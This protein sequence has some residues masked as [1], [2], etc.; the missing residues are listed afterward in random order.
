MGWSAF[1]PVGLTHHNPTSS[2]KG[3]TL[4]TPT[5][6]RGIYLLNM[7][8]QVVKRWE[9]EDIKTNLAE[10]LPNGRLFITAT[11]L[12]AKQKARALD[13]EDYDDLG[14]FCIKQGGGCYNT[15]REYDWDGNL[16]W[17][18]EADCIH[19]DFHI[20]DNG[21]VFIPQWV[22]LPQELADRVEGGYRGAPKRPFLLGDDVVRINRQGEEVDRWHI[23]QMLD[24]VED[25]IGPLQNKWEWTHMNSVEVRPDGNIL[26]SLCENSRVIIFNP[27]TR[28]LVWKLGD[29]EISM[30]HHATTVPN[31]NVQIFDNGRKKPS[32]IPFSR[33]IE[34][35]PENDEIVWTYQPGNAEQFFSGHISSAQRLPHGNVLICE[36]TSGRL[37]EVTRSGDI[38]WEW[39]NPFIWGNDEGR[40]YQWIYRANRYPL[41][42]AAFEGKVLDAAAY[43]NINEG[44]GLM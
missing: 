10:L 27:E 24:P 25:P 17:S 11:T 42:H 21:D 13:E 20:C 41:D 15:L 1:R 33:V 7:A 44:Y 28:E 14:L 26:C 40:L 34:V 8:G 2:V 35:N 31:G 23:W 3:Y 18:Y 39:I 29:P 22:K 12:E 43:H 19:H 30:Q 32:A 5:H 9:F 4:F 16:L 36:G 38:V 37:F 6:A